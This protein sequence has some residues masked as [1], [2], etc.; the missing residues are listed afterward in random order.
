MQKVKNRR[1]PIRKAY[2]GVTSPRRL[3]F[4]RR[5]LMWRSTTIAIIKHNTNPWWWDKRKYPLPPRPH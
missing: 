2:R 1:N 3:K 4:M 5:L